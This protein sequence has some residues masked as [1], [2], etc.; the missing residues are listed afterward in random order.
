MKLAAFHEGLLLDPTNTGKSMAGLIDMI[1]K[2]R[3]SK[4]QNV[5]Y[6]HTGERR[7]CLGIRSW[8]VRKTMNIDHLVLPYNHILFRYKLIYGCL[9]NSLLI[10]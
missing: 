3:F 4:G 9:M 6:L 1:R 5:V 2:G 10:Q 8:W 7:H